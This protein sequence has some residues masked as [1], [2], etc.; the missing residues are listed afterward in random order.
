[1]TEVFQ[2]ALLGLGVGAAYT[3][4]AQG[5]VVIYRGSGILNFAQGAFAMAGAYIFWELRFETGWAFAP[6]FVVAV[7]CVAAIGVL[8]QFLVMRRLRTASALTRLIAT[9]AV[10]AVITAIATMR[11]HALIEIVPSSLPQSL[12]HIFGATITS[13]QLWL[14][15]IAAGLTAALSL[16]TRYTTIGLAATATAENQQAASSL[17][18]S[19]DG[20]AALTWGLGGALAATAGILIAPLSGLA[21]TNF[22][23][24]LITTMAAALVGGFSSYWLTFLAAVVLGVGQ[25]EMARYVTWPGAA[26]SLPFVVMVVVLLVRGKALPLR[27]QVLDRLPTLG[28]G[29]PKIKAIAI[30]TGLLAIGIV[31]VMPVELTIAVTVQATIGIVLLSIV[32]LTGYAGQLSLAQFAIAGIGALIAG[33]L[34]AAADLP[35]AAAL[36][37]GVAGT[38]PIG[39]VIGLP[40]LRTRGI[41][42]AVMTV[43]LGVTVS[44]VVFANNTLS[45]GINGLNLGPASFLGLDLDP[46]RFPER[47]ALFSIFWFVVASLVVANVRRSRVGRRLI[48]IRANERAAASLGVSVLGGKVFAFG[49]AAGLAALG[50][51]LLSFQNYYLTFATFDPITSVNLV[52]NAVIGGVGFVTGAIAASGFYPGGIGA[53]ALGG[54][55]GLDSWLALIGALALLLTLLLNPN[56]IVD[57]LSRGKGDPITRSIV[58]AY[59][60]RRN[61]RQLA[62]RTSLLAA[63]SPSDELPPIVRSSGGYL[64]V[65]DVTVAF[66]GVVAVDGVSLRVE[67]GEIVGLIGP[68]GAGKTTMIDAITGFVEPRGGS[69]AL[70]GRDLRRMSTYKRARSGISRSWQSVELIDGLSVFENIQLACDSRDKLAYLSTLIRTGRRDL[71]DAGRAAIREFHLEPFLHEDPSG[72]PYGH[73]RLVSIARA[74]ASQPEILLLDEPASGL[75]ETETR[76]LAQLIRRLA[77]VWGVGILLVEHDMS[78]VMSVCDKIAVLDFGKLIAEGTPEEIQQSSAVVAAYLGVADPEE[79]A[80]GTD[81]F[82]DHQGVEAPL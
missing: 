68:N 26:D 75:D 64:E 38:V 4:L 69:V 79:G 46:V 8:T 39:M 12:V 61:A 54:I 74:A 36:V 19:P 45:G 76:E 66:G 10:L 32:V 58:A 13:D 24:V 25:S 14:L 67:A 3:L 30:C 28:S 35:F 50:G 9:L 7:S 62:R 63:A 55:G 2:F 23:L 60:K 22:T 56:G 31:T 44:S 33:Q 72:I 82:A 48:A 53:W 27:S 73:R 29:I 11:Y 59:R 18:W 5:L 77:D 34:V 16:V 37:L 1:V 17:G 65:R 41:S 81:H 40:A 57:E 47:Y 78:V 6:A 52:G 49:F 15:A 71:T 20:L 21:V 70:N 42:L 43:G 51:I 80:L